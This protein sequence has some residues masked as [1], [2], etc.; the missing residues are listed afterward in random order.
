MPPHWT[1]REAVDFNARLKQPHA[2]RAKRAELVD[3]LMETFGLTVVADSFIG[4]EM[5]RGISGGQRR[6]VTLARGVAAQASLL[7][8]DE[9]TSGLSAT[10]AELCIK[11]LHDIAKSVGVLILVVIHQP[12]PEVAQLFDTLVLLTSDPGRVCY[13]GPMGQ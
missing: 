9:P 1:V 8:C 5:V 6:R 12:R 10:D 4:G 2:S 3:T 7:F 13:M 11:A